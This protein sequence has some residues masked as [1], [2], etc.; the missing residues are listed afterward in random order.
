MRM[1][2]RALPLPRRQGPDEPGLAL[3]A[4]LRARDAGRLRGYQ[5][6]LDFYDG[7]HF[8]R[9]RRGRTSLVV[10]YARAVAD[11]GVAYL[12]GRGVRFSVPV[13]REEAAPTPPSPAAAGKG[14]SS[15]PSPA[16][17]REGALP[18]PRPPLGGEAGR[19]DKARAGEGAPGAGEEKARAAERLLNRIAEENDLDLVLLQAAT[20]ASVL[21]DAVLK[22][23][24]DAAGRVRV[25]NV[26]PFCFFPTW[27]SDDIATLREVVLAGRVSAAEA[28]ERFGVTRGPAP[29][30]SA[31]APAMLDTIERWTDARFQLVVGDQVVRDGPNPYGF[32]PF[33]H[34]ANLQPPNS[35]WGVSD[36]AQLIALNRELD[37]RMSDQAD[38]IRYHADPPVVFRGIEEHSDLP[39]GPGTVWDLPRDAD[40]ALLEW[41]GNAPALQDHIERVLRAIYDVSETPRTSFGDSGRLLSGVALETELQPLVHRTLRK[42]VGWSAALRRCARMVL[43]LV[44]RFEPGRAPGA[45]APYRAQVIWPQMLPRDDDADAQRNLSLVQGGLRSHR[46]AM[47][48]LGDLDPE[49]ELERVRADR[50]FLDPP[51]TVL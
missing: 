13:E 49:V 14:A 6:L 45:F 23:L 26:D 29:S 15:P 17:A 21:G 46:G 10:N 41:R 2:A 24:W 1:I 30:G 34:V 9:P 19:A 28:A 35:A 32:I 39:V 38:L 47:E 5:D 22:V 8:T 40:V 20:N 33:V 42:R 48:A 37:E 43:T 31:A 11:K 18:L 25:V 7:T 50:A 51:R 16:V 27:A 36:L 3:L 12:F 4:Q 44:E